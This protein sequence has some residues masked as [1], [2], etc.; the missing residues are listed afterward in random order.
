MDYMLNREALA[1]SE[2]IYDGCQEQPVDLDISLPDYCPDI[3]KILKC[4]VYPRITSRGVTGDK[5]EVEGNYTVR[6]FY[7]DA[8][9]ATVR[10]C[11]SSSSFYSSA[12]LKQAPENP[13]VFASVRV[14]YINCRATS[15]R[16]LDIHGAFSV[17]GKV[18]CQNSCEV[19]CNIEG[20]DIEQRSMELPFSRIAAFS[21][22]QF[23]VDEVLELGQGKLEPDNILRT[24]A[25]ATLTDYSIVANKIMA[26]GDVCIKFLYASAEGALESMEYAIPYNEMLDCDGVT[27]DCMCDIRITV[28][29]ISVQIKNDYSGDSVYFDTQ[30]RLFAAAV[31]YEKTSIDIVTDA[32][33]KLYDLDI[34]AKQKTF[35]N[36]VDLLQET[37]AAKASLEVSDSIS[38]IIDVWNEMS[39]VTATKEGGA[40]QFRGKLNIC[41]L[42]INEDG[43]PFYF[44]RMVD[45]EYACSWQGEQPQLKCDAAVTV[46]GI[47]Y[48]ITGD[49][50]DIK[51]DLQLTA[52]I[53]SQD[54][55]KVIYDVTADET[56]PRIRENAALNIYYADAGETL[57]DIA[58]TYCTSVDAIKLENDLNCDAVENRCMLLIP[59]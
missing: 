51:A 59:C 57:W 10:C 40:I 34:N 32:Y 8:N 33:S 38:K 26:K 9:A 6:V 31:A 19:A 37:Y 45:F 2:I 16:R 12:S 42:A 58:R 20:D 52:S 25:F 24:D 35:D 11:E 29:D 17:C 56:K 18:L 7:L 44:E 13:R 27:E 46:E 3:Q 54:T 48:R 47:G 21:Q 53:F 36:L 1:T 39:T 4:Q 43:R 23:S 5:L 28:S 22:Q 15:P 30:V 14:E 49:G 55:C 50:L 41:V